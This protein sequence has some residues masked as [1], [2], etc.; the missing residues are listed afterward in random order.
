MVQDNYNQFG[1]SEISKNKQGLFAS[2]FRVK[3]E[4][5]GKL[6]GIKWGFEAMPIIVKMD[7]TYAPLDKLDPTSVIIDSVN[8]VNNGSKE[9]QQ[10]VS[11]TKTHVITNQWNVDQTSTQGYEISQGVS[12]SPVQWAEQQISYSS[13]KST[14]SSFGFNKAVETTFSSNQQT[15]VIIP[16]GKQIE[17]KSVILEQKVNVPFEATLTFADRFTKQIIGSKVVKGVW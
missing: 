5:N 14:T 4:P 17:V 7:V 1:L 13:Y 6:T 3:Y 15:L 12:I 16:P 9:A 11:F 2:S 10:T 8:V